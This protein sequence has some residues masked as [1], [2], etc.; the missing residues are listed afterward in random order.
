LEGDVECGSVGDEEKGVDVL[1][2]SEEES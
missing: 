1:V 2:D